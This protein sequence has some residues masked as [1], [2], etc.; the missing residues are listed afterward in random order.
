MGGK[1]IG[2][3]EI[4]TAAAFTLLCFCLTLFVWISFGGKVPLQSK[5]YRI[6]AS[7]DQAASLADNEEVRIAGVPV[8]KVTRVTPSSGLTDAELEL[9]RQYAPLASDSRAI[10]R[11]KT[12]LGENFVD[13]SPGTNAAPKI[14]EGG[15]LSTSNIAPT[16]QV[17]QVL[18]AFDAPTRDA[19]KKFLREA[20]STLKG[21]GADLNAALGQVVPAAQDLQQVVDILDQQGG[22]VRSL[23]NDTGVAL[24][25]IGHRRG[26]LQGLISAGNRVFAATAASG[27]DL[28]ATVRALPPFL[29]Q[30]RP[31]LA[32]LG[33]TSRDAAPTLRALRPVAPLLRPALVY[34][35]RLSPQLVALFHEI[36]PLLSAAGVGLPAATQIADA[37]P[38]LAGALDAAGRQLVPVVQFLGLYP[39]DAVAAL[40]NLGSALEA[41]TPLPGGGSQHYLRAQL[42]LNN[43]IPLGATQRLGSNRHNPYPVPGTFNLANGIAAFDC[44]N[45]G[46][47]TTIPV[48]GTGTPACNAQRP[49]SF[50]GL[51]QSFPQVQ[52][53]VP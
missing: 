47:P 9:D 13:I 52:P 27:R 41:T 15:R 18:S 5:G 51:T 28:S 31:T 14:P 25:A 17:D 38:P 16:Q 42:P 22:D 45:T 40:A 23:I 36:D 44:L 21:H 43:E 2:R 10:L 12:L 3:R 29:A 7:F 24:R 8:G 32:L 30:L 20:S 37:V 35:N 11:S 50:Q 53:F 48:L 33:A 34:T 26:D 39:N 1:P 4:I 6:R 46:N 19:L 49:L